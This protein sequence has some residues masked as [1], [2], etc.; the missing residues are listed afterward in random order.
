M[1]Q[2]VPLQLINAAVVIIS[3]SAVC[4]IVGIKLQHCDIFE[5]I[6]VCQKTHKSPAMPL[7]YSADISHTDANCQ[8]EPLAPLRTFSNRRASSMEFSHMTT[9]NKR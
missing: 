4:N 6:L 8:N 5:V 9:P 7:N 1:A 2:Q 3:V